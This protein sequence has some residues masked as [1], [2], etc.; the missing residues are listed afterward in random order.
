[1]LATLTESQDAPGDLD[2][3]DYSSEDLTDL[4]TPL[5]GPKD[6]YALIPAIFKPCPDVCWNHAHPKRFDCGGGKPHRH[7]YNVTALTAFAADLDDITEA[8]GQAVVASLQARGT[9]FYIW[10]TFS[11]APALAAKGEAAARYRVLIPFAKPLEISTPEQWSKGVWP[12]LVRHFGV[13]QER[14]RSCSDPCRLYYLPRHPEGETRESVHFPGTLFDPHAFLEPH[15]GVAGLIPAKPLPVPVLPGEDEDLNRPVPLDDVRAKLADTRNPTTRDLARRCIAGELLTSLPKDRAPG[16][17]ARHDAWWLLTGRLSIVAEPWMSTEAL[18]SILK[19]SHTREREMS[20]DD[21]TPWDD[22]RDSVVEMFVGQRATAPTRRAQYQA[23]R[24]AHRAVARNALSRVLQRRGRPALDE[25]REPPGNPDEAEDEADGDVG[26]HAEPEATPAVEA[27]SVDEVRDALEAKH[28]ATGSTTYLGTLQNLATLFTRAPAWAGA[29]RRNMLTNEFEIWPCEGLGND[30]VERFSDGLITS[31]RLMLALDDDYPVK[32]GREEVIQAAEWAAA[33]AP[34]EPVQEYLSKAHED[35]DHGKRLDTWLVDYLNARTTDEDGTD[36]REYLTAIG[37]RWMISAVARAFEPGCQ[38]D[39]MLQLESPEQGLGKSSAL[40]VLGGEWFLE[41][42]MDFE[43]KDTAVLISTAWL[44]ELG[45]NASFDKAAEGVQKAFLTRRVDSLV[46]KF[47][48][49]RSDLPRRCVF[50]GT[51]NLQ[52]YLTDQTGN[53]RHWVFRV[54]GPIDCARLRRDRDHL[55]A[56]A[57]EAYRA[58]EQWHL[59]PGEAT[60]AKAEAAKRLRGGDMFGE[61]I[62]SWFRRTPKAKRPKGVQPVDIARHVFDDKRGS[63]PKYKITGALRKLGFV[64]K[65]MRVDGVVVR[66]WATPAELLEAPFEGD[67]PAQ[68]IAQ[69]KPTEPAQA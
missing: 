30:K 58:G 36:L 20:P 39:N 11:H 33:Q 13:E 56:E 10:E 64:N 55:W 16:D 27:W 51:T 7:R 31:L 21:F 62:E 6:G 28:T 4:L 29:F 35:W 38:A 8:Q 57:V 3:D 41:A 22:D 50:A 5:E 18:L 59:T 34:Y 45:E 23:E 65:T 48:R 26:G 15:G 61:H 54:A 66:R 14:D 68:K 17:L 1:M 37:R 24:D 2:L 19:P 40:K 44:V 49:Y 47:E 67:T 43:S 9:D 53:R 42:T 52:E 25:A 12:M 46:R 32:A 63:T 69:A 60:L